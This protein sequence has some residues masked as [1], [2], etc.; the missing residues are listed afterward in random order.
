MNENG[1]QSWPLEYPRYHNHCSDPCDVIVGPCVCSAFHSKDEFI[2]DGERLYRFG[3]LVSS[4]FPRE[5]DLRKIGPNSNHDVGYQGVFSTLNDF[6][7]S[8]ENFGRNLY[9]KHLSRIDQFELRMA[10]AYQERLQYSGQI[11]NFPEWL[12]HYKPLLYKQFLESNK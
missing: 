5:S 8:L 12:R 1:I 6:D 9:D 10:L 2:Y 4:Y 11:N 3:R 7:K